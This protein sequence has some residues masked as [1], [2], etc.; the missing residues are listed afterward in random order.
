MQAV[1]SVF[2]PDAPVDAARRLGRVAAEEA[3]LASDE[4][5]Q[6]R[7]HHLVE[8]KDR[9]AALVKGVRSRETGETACIVSCS[10][11][12]LDAPPT[13]MARILR[14]VR[15]GGKKER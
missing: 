8:Y 12:C 13:T 2:Q 10:V 7:A 5:E 9:R 4:P 6:R 1:D 11:T 3:L 15:G 14:G